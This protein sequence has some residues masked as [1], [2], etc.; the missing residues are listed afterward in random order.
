MNEERLIYK[1]KRTEIGFLL[2]IVLLLTLFLLSISNF[3]KLNNFFYEVHRGWPVD[4]YFR[5][6]FVMFVGVFGLMM[7]AFL[8][9]KDYRKII[10]KMSEKDWED[11]KVQKCKGEPYGYYFK[12]LLPRIVFNLTIL[13]VIVYSWSG[14]ADSWVFYLLFI[15]L[16][17]NIGFRV[18]KLK[19]LTLKPPN[20]I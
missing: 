14:I 16:G 8:T 19:G 6:G 10:T 7:K 3:L 17:F 12:Q 13:F 4:F 5:F 18:E 9:E 2:L 11:D 20:V 1:G 15:L